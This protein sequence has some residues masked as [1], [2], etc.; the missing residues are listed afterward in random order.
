MSDLPSNKDSKSKNIKLALVF[1]ALAVLWF[2]VS[3]A[4]IWNQ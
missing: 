2:F 4:V 1:G 3:M